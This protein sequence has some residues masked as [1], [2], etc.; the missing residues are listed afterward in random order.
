MGVSWKRTT[1][2]DGCNVAKA[3]RPRCFAGAGLGART[4]VDEGSAE[5]R[6]SGAFARFS[7]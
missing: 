5:S 3:L 6:I 7:V 1:C 2:G 4:A